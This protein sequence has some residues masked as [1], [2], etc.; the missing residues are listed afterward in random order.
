MPRP[1]LPIFVVAA[2]A[3][4]S[5]RAKNNKESIIAIS[6]L[7]A[8]IF[9]SHVRLRTLVR[10]T[11]LEQLEMHELFKNQLVRRLRKYRS[12]QIRDL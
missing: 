11:V 12:D 10:R 2:R 3:S 6:L 5:V 9:G 7:L 1:L 4:T 8:M